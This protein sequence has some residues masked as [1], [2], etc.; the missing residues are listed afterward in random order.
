MVTL[1]HH[2]ITYLLFSL[3]S[4][5]LQQSRVHTVTEGSWKVME[6]HGNI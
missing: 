1:C 4:A 3:V 5:R 6:S 2:V